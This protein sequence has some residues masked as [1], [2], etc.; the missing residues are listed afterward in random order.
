MD[1]NRVHFWAKTTKAGRPGIS[2]HDHCLNVGCVAEALVAA[3][4]PNVRNL[5]PGENGRAATLLT[6]LHDVGKITI[7]FQA[8]CPAWLTSVELPPC[9]PGQMAL[10]V[11]DHAFVSQAFL[12]KLPEAASVRL[13]CVAVGAHHGRPKGRSV[14]LNNGNHLEALADW[15][16]AHRHQLLAE[17][18]S[19]FGPLP[20]RPPNSNLAD[21]WLLAGLITVADWIGSNETWFS[22]DEGLPQEAARA[23]AREAVRQIGWPGGKLRQ[24]NFAAAFG[25]DVAPGFEPNKVQTAVAAASLQP[26]VIVVEGPMGCGKTE[27]ALFAAQQLIAAGHHQGIYF[28]LP[29]QVTSNRIHRRIERFLRNT[30]AEDAP[31]RLAHGNAWLEADFI[32]RL[33]PSFTHWEEKDQDHPDDHVREARSWFA[34]AKQALLATYGVG[35]IDQALQAVVAVKHFFVRRFALAG[36]VV[37]LDEIHSYDIYT[38]TLITALIRELV[39]LRCTVIILSATLTA[40]RRRELLAAANIQET[41]APSAYPLITSGTPG[42]TAL[43]A[44]APDWP[45]RRPI[46]LRPTAIPEGEV[47]DELIGRAEAGQHVLWIRNTVVEAQESFRAVSGSVREDTVRVGLL[48]SRF[49]FHRRAELEDDWLELLG[50]NRPA[51][52]PGSILIAT[53]VVEQSVDIDLD[54]IASDLAPTDMLLQRVGRLWRHERPHRQATAPEF[55]IRLPDLPTTD[56]ARE[57]TKALGRSARVYAP[58]V[59]LRTMGVWRAKTEL[60]LPADIRP[61]L[62]ATYAKPATDEPQTWQELHAQLETEKRQLTANAEAATRVLGNPMLDDKEE[63]LTRRK[64]APTTPVVLLRSLTTGANGT[65]LAVALDGTRAEISEHE[66][67]RDSAKFLHQWIVRAPRWMVPANAPRPRWLVLHGSSGATVATVGDNGRCAFG[68]ELSAMTYDPRLGIFAER[69]TKTTPQRK[70]DDDEF[71]S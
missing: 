59:L 24:T 32:Q 10:S 42:T 23:Q 25:T 28:A 57:L 67:R 17:L 22:P 60:R 48:H 68:E 16:E 3:L 20:A 9:P 40:D 45:D 13:W 51:D 71:D 58:Y 47:I 11:T 53:Q 38:G 19:V 50:K 35:T 65:V 56:D 12:Q 14:R 43:P 33:T 30:L 55:W 1:W 52:G 6:A 29:T 41:E 2:V 64:S 37:I 21:L 44:V 8:K 15:A 62:E 63:I 70:N 46:A 49:P 66:W 61:L 54:F 5:L 69:P 4:P 34:S 39:N 26:G 7:G 31:L 27:A 36:K 18:Q